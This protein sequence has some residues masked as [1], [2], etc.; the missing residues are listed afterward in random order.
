MNSPFSTS[1]YITDPDLRYVVSSN[2]ASVNAYFEANIPLAMIAD[3]AL[4]GYYVADF[5]K[6]VRLGMARFAHDT[7]WHPHSLHYIE[8]G[9]SAMGAVDTLILLEQAAEMILTQIGIELFEHF[10][11][12]PF[13]YTH[14][15]AQALGSL[16]KKLIA[17]QECL[18]TLNQCYLATHPKLQLITPKELDTLIANTHP[19]LGEFDVLC[20]KYQLTLVANMGQC[21]WHGMP[22]TQLLTSA[23]V[24]MAVNDQLYQLTGEPFLY[25]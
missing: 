24:L 5:D 7:R 10:C 19:P 17:T 25:S 18:H 16:D 3:E 12:I 2:I 21:T 15:V 4:Y 11:D 6:R 8:F 22:A 20:H 23:G 14:Q 13:D 1:I 9:L